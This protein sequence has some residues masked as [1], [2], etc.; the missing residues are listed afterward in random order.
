[1]ANKTKIDRDTLVALLVERDGTMCQYPD[2]ENE[3]D[4]TAKDTRKEVTIDHTFPQSKARLA[5]W[6]EEE[7]WD[8]SNLTL[9]EKSCNAKKSDLVYRE[10]GTLPQKPMSRFKQRRIAR[11]ER[12][13]ICQTCDNGRKLGPDE[14][15]GA[16]G[17]GP[18]PERF[19]RWA[20][21]S[22]N[23]CDHEAFWC[24]ACSIGMTE[25]KA[26]YVDV[27]DIEYS[28]IED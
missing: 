13:A 14:N 9:M 28:G 6:T 3:L 25:R 12:P 10:D 19:P 15:C 4:F 8:L 20:K 16:C 21:M 7:I 5:G 2:C 22:A 1:M 17:S 27:F 24:W 26:A 23:D 18:M 11:A